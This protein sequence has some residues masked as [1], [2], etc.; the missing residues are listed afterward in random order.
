MGRK[1]RW[2]KPPQN[3]AA[4]QH[5]HPQ[6]QTWG[7]VI[8]FQHWP[9]G[10]MC[11]DKCIHAAAAAV[12]VADTAGL[13][14]TTLAGLPA[15]QP[16]VSEPSSPVRHITSTHTTALTACSR[17]TDTNVDLKA[18]VAGRRMR[19]EIILD[20]SASKQQRPALQH[21]QSKHVQLQRHSNWCRCCYCLLRLCS[22]CASCNNPD[23]P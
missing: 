12:A 4:T 13:L 23:Q 17:T 14:L 2:D 8:L 21:L 19:I 5:T 18:N 3:T 11:S 7:S 16:A 6:G 9:A 20:V 10:V 1:A 15:H 22:A